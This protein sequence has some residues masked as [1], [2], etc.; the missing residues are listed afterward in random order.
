M[1]SM[2]VH[3]TPA[4]PTATPRV[5]PASPRVPMTSAV[6]TP[7]PQARVPAPYMPTARGGYAPSQY[8]TTHSMPIGA[9]PYSPRG[10]VMAGPRISG[11]TAGYTGGGYSVPYGG[12]YGVRYR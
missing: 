7:A 12:G 10:P 3:H 11:G 6:P 4:L 5:M 9:S 1:A 8:P 2:P